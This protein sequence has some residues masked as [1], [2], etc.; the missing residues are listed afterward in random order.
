MQVDS[1]ATAHCAAD[2]YHLVLGGKCHSDSA[3]HA[4]MEL[5][6]VLFDS[7]CL[8]LEEVQEVALGCDGTTT[9]YSR[10]AF[11]VHLVYTQKVELADPTDITEKDAVGLFEKGCRVLGPLERKT[12]GT[13]CATYRHLLVHV[14]YL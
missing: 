4:F 14:C 3:Q 11:E 5:D 10:S 9:W 13:E 12:R 6:S 2:S 8:E 7:M 1:G